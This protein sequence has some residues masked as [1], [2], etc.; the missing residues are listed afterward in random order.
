MGG[1]E[2]ASKKKKNS[3]WQNVG[4]VLCL[5]RT[6]TT[7]TQEGHQHAPP[8]PPG[9]PGRGGE[10]RGESADRWACMRGSS[11][12]P[13]SRAL[14]GRRCERAWA[15][16]VSPT[17]WLNRAAYL[18][19]TRSVEAGL[20]RR[21][22]RQRASIVFS[23]FVQTQLNSTPSHTTGPHRLRH[24]PPTTPLPGPVPS[25]HSDSGSTPGP[26]CRGAAPPAGGVQGKR[27]GEPVAAGAARVP[28]PLS[29]RLWRR[30]PRR[31]R[32][33]RLRAGGRRGD[34]GLDDGRAGDAPR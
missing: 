9:G 6:H 4:R 21:P 17:P 27:G 25:R 13:C 28:R 20:V 14:A 30:L 16:P 8:R 32:G 24:A 5:S 19:G 11:F 33:G 1:V 29:P 26:A 10:W 18:N 23:R 22:R 15:K 7:H 31:A 2:R 34:R 3:H 12:S